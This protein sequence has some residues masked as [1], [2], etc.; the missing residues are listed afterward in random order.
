MAG[1]GSTYSADDLDVPPAVPAR[2]RARKCLS[3]YGD[4]G[5]SISPLQPRPLRVRKEPLVL[6]AEADSPGGIREEAA[7]GRSKSRTPVAV[8]DVKP[9]WEQ[10]WDLGGHTT[11]PP[12]AILL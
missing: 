3:V 2:S 8:D 9:E 6:A 5:S 1:G 10:F 4:G 7:R 12:T 11:L